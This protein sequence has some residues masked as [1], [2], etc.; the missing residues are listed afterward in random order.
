MKIF[1]TSFIIALSIILPIGSGIAEN[2]TVATPKI[3]NNL[4]VKPAAE[5]KKQYNAPLTSHITAY[6]PLKYQRKYYKDVNNINDRMRKGLRKISYLYLVS[7]KDMNK[8]SGKRWRTP[9][10]SNKYCASIVGEKLKSHRVIFGNVKI[11]EKK[12]Y[13]TLGKTGSDQ[14]LLGLKNPK[15]YVI[16]FLLPFC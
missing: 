11:Y 5:V 14:Y 9:R 8:Y 1:I 15:N 2:S 12:Y 4:N 16:H 7:K 6:L 10:C 13:N 3:Q